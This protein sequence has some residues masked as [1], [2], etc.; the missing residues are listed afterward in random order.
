MLAL[1]AGLPLAAS[2]ALTLAA[3]LALAPAPAPFPALRPAASASLCGN[4]CYGDP[5]HLDA[6][7]ARAINPHTH[8][9][10]GEG[11]GTQYIKWIF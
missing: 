10:G 2:L 11:G 5:W 6:V 3:A 8:T 4:S 7:V 9:E 1:A